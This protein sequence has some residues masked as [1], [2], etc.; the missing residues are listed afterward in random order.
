MT[1]K[2]QL[3]AFD[4]ACIDLRILCTE[5]LRRGKLRAR[6]WGAMDRAWLAW[7]KTKEG[8]EP[9]HPDDDDVARMLSAAASAAH[10][11]YGYQVQ[12]RLLPSWK[13][14]W[15]T[16]R[17][18]QDALKWWHN[19]VLETLSPKLQ[20]LIG[21]PM[22]ARFASDYPECL[23]IIVF[24]DVN[25]SRMDE[26]AE[27]TDSISSGALRFCANVVENAEHLIA[28]C[29]ADKFDEAWEQSW[30]HCIATV[31]HENVEPNPTT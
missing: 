24:G 25:P 26:C 8:P 3:A 10:Y 27:L 18:S 22:R 9:A 15:A 5:W 11:E 19:R 20:D 1:I 13:D 16:M 29:D 12:K 2:E 14:S 7:L 4:V 21:T 28:L 30:N 31:R 6:H 17:E 23:Q